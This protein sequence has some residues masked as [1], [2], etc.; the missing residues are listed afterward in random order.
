MSRQIQTATLRLWGY[1]AALVLLAI[2]HFST[3]GFGPSHEQLIKLPAA[4]RHQ[5]VAVAGVGAE[6]GERH[7]YL[8]APGTVTPF[9][10]VTMRTRVDGE[11]VH[12]YFSEGQTVKVGD[13][14][15]EIDPRLYQVRLTEAE[16]QMAR[17]RAS[18]VNAQAQLARFKEL[19]NEKIIAR[20]EL[21]SQQAL[22]GQYAGMV[23][24]DQGLIDAAR[25]E[26]AYCRIASPIS[27]RVGLRL[28]DPGNIVH[29]T[30]AQ[31]LMVIRFNLSR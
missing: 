17:D 27:G 1:A 24:N 8:N 31:G 10:T 26:L 18:L 4:V 7:R 3:A 28:V 14:L 21:D 9:A 29:V 13:L 22:A 2:L 20:Q 5:N 11:L 15:A 19:F 16:G 30:D 23:R 25:L 6:H 12:V